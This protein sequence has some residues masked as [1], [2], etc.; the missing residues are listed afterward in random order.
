[1][2]NILYTFLLLVAFINN[3]N[4]QNN[5]HDTQGSLEVGGAG[6]VNYTLKIANPPTQGD[7]APVI[8]LVYSSGQFGGIA[9]QGWNITGI[10]AIMH[11]ATRRD[12]D[13]FIDGVDY[14]SH[15]KLSLNGQRL[16]LKTGTYLQP[17]ALYMT[18]TQSN[19]KIEHFGIAGNRASTYFVVTM[20]DGTRS[21]Y[22]NYGGIYAIE[23]TAYYL[24][25]QEDTD[26][27]YITYH[28][29]KPII[30][31]GTSLCISEIRYSANVSNSQ[32]PLNKITFTY[33]KAVRSEFAYVGGEKKEKT[34]LLTQITVFTNNLQFKKYLL[35]H[36][37]DSQLGYQK[38]TKIQEY[39]NNNE[40]ANP[41][42]FEYGNTVS[43]IVNSEISKQ[44]NLNLD[45]T[46]INLSGDFDGDGFLDLCSGNGI[47]TQL[48]QNTQNNNPVTIPNDISNNDKKFV[49]TTLKNNKLN[50]KN[51][52]IIPNEEVG[53]MNFSTYNLENNQLVF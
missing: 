23:N 21:W 17:G 33:T 38:V 46:T 4:A 34:E 51:S 5:F 11:T 8:N 45:F 37:T 12:I 28:Y 22:G 25:R 27:N 18:E 14:D 30:S 3:T 49:A 1:M 9:G 52:I 15:D 40:P 44:Y 10:S 24:V 43:T 31:G 53:S 36:A 29:E 50:T 19:T 26:G 13:G 32:A 2:K 16:L 48:F 35:T 39:N 20:P 47:Y 42:E 7:F 41:V 6:N